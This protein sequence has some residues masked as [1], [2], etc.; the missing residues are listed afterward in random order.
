MR[1]LQLEQSCGW[2]LPNRASPPIETCDLVLQTQSLEK[3]CAAWLLFSAADAHVFGMYA[4]VSVIMYEGWMDGCVKTAYYKK[5]HVQKRWFGLSLRSRSVNLYSGVPFLL[6]LST[7]SLIISS[8]VQICRLHNAYWLLLIL[9]HI[10]INY[11]MHMQ[12]AADCFRT[13]SSQVAA[14]GVEDAMV[15][16]STQSLTVS[17]WRGWKLWELLPM[18]LDH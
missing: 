2:R 4:Y 5:S 6:F 18:I 11:C 7:I 16:V 1:I 13:L 9:L 8:F 12:T 3:P 15:E 17:W 10:I 14:S